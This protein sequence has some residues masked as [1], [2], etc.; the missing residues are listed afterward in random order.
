MQTEELYLSSEGGEITPTHHYLIPS[1][2]VVANQG[3][4]TQYRLLA[5]LENQKSAD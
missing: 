3:A 5:K 4:D 1:L 2:R